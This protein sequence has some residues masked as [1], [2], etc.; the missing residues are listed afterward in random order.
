MGRVES[1][2]GGQTGQKGRNMKENASADDRRVSA[3]E[4]KD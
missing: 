4:R 3:K 2:T 1:M